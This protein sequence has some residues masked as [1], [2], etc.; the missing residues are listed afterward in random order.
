MVDCVQSSK[1]G[2]GQ[3]TGNVGPDIERHIDGC[4]V[5]ATLRPVYRHVGIE[6]AVPGSERIALATLND[7]V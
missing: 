1:V 2:G 7:F 6:A 3:E 5:R 4:F